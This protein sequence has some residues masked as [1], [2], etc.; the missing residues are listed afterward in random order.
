MANRISKL[1]TLF[2]LNATIEIFGPC[3]ILARALQSPKQTAAGVYRSVQIV[4]SQL[5]AM[6]TSNAFQ[7][8]YKATTD[9]GSSLVC[10]QQLQEQERYRKN[11]NTQQMPSRPQNLT[12]KQILG[13]IILKF[14]IC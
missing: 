11:S 5:K 6:R 1:E 9:E 8:I 4:V 13:K 2:Y 12:G 10:I 14:L 7:K 3:E